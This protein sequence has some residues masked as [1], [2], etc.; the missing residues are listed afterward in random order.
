MNVRTNLRLLRG[1]TPI[2]D[3]AEKAGVSRGT[4]SLLERGLALP[5]DRQIE[6][7]ER[8]YGPREAW[9]P[10]SVA[11]VLGP[12]ASPCPVCER[13]LDPSVSRRRRYHDGCRPHSKR[14]AA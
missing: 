7:L 11:H 2:R 12:E 9:Y 5:R 10:P 4:L 1:E 14:R 6:D 13:P 8:V 3:A